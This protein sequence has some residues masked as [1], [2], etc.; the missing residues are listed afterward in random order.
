[1][2]LV[3]VINIPRTLSIPQRE[4]S[5]APVRTK[6]II[7]LPGFTANTHL[8]LHPVRLAMD[9]ERFAVHRERF[10]VYSERLPSPINTQPRIE[11]VAIPFRLMG[12]DP[13]ALP[14]KIFGNF[15]K[16]ADETA[17]PHY[18]TW[19]PIDLPQPNYHCPE[20][21]GEIRF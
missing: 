9:S 4:S 21:F 11:R 17:Y 6:Y 18:L 3:N 13:S 8:T 1:M 7:P 19:N 20:F 2:L 16:C 5:V 14:E 15:C 10:A 12:V